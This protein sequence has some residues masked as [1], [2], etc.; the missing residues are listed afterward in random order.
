MRLCY[1]WCFSL[2]GTCVDFI[3]KE[4]KELDEKSEETSQI[5]WHSGFAGGL[6]L[7]LKDYL[8][9][10]EISREVQL[11]KVPIRMQMQ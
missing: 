1:G 11:T 9:D 4:D 3:I 8:Q 6:N 7:S 2:K 5:D 10:I